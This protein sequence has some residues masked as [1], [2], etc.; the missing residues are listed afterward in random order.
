MSFFKRLK[1]SISNKTEAVTNK[2]KEGLTKTRDAFVDRVDDLFSR[3]KKI[4]EDFY[5]ELEEILIGAD[6]GVNTVLKL[7]DELRSEGKKLNIED[8]SELHLIL[9][10]K[11]IG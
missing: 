10:E 2:F 8:P 4:D 9:S 11:L 7:I 5:E 1:E 3:R 6:V